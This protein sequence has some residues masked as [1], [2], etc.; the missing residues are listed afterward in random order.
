MY[1]PMAA[2][3]AA[4]T[5][6]PVVFL[7][8]G[9]RVRKVRRSPSTALQVTMIVFVDMHPGPVYLQPDIQMRVVLVIIPPLQITLN[10][11]LLKYGEHLEIK[12]EGRYNL[13]STFVFHTASTS[14]LSLH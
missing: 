11:F 6:P 7:V 4:G 12:F 10:Q 13:L 3:R 5:R 8:Q 14:V 2:W 1:P 9:S